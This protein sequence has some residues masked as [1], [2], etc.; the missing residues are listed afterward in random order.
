RMGAF[1]LPKSANVEKWSVEQVTVFAFA[2]TRQSLR[3]SHVPFH[4]YMTNDDSSISM[5]SS[6]PYASV[7]D[8]GSWNDS[9]ISSVSVTACSSYVYAPTAARPAGLLVDASAA[10][11]SIFFI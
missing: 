5:T 4:R 7:R 8:M 11:S 2:S 9:M 3:A 10:L 6:G 1:A